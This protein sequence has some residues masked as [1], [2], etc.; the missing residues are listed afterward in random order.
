MHPI[1]LA[2]LVADFLLQPKWLVGWKEKSGR[3]IAVHGAIHALALFAVLAPRRFDVFT[4]IL[5]IALAHGL[6]DAVKIRWQKK[7]AAFDLFFVVDQLA[8]LAV[9]AAAAWLI[10]PAVPTFWAGD[11]GWIIFAVLFL[12][13]F[14]VA[15]WH[16]SHLQKFP[17]KTYAQ[18][19]TRFAL[20]ALVFAL[21]AIPSLLLSSSFCSWL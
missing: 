3:G 14:G 15:W 21:F 8:H 13:S 9:L 5:G 6:I 16:L 1:F 18:R 19:L 7:A 17:L 10:R 2:H 4:L 20:L 11:I 12:F